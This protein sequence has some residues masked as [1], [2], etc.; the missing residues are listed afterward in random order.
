MCG[1]QWEFCEKVRILSVTEDD[2]YFCTRTLAA[3]SYKQAHYSWYRLS[4]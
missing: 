1:S 3:I 2:I 4:K